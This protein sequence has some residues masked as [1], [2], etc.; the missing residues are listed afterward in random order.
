[1]SKRGFLPPSRV[2]IVAYLPKT[3]KRFH[4]SILQ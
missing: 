4:N 3:F 2:F 1:M